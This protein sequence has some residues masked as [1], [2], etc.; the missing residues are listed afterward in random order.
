[1]MKRLLL[2]FAF[3]CFGYIVSAQTKDEALAIQLVTQNSEALKLTPE[4][5]SNF[6][7]SSTYFN[8][9]SG[10]QL[11]YLLQ[12]FKGLPVRN[13]MMVL[14]F[15][16]GKPVSNTGGFI[17]DIAKYT[18]ASSAPSVNA[19]AAIGAA[20]REAKLSSP[21]G[22]QVMGSPVNGKFNYG[23]L[24]G[25]TEN[26]T[27]ELMWTVI[28][29][30]NTKSVKL[31]WE[32]QVVPAK[33]DDYW[34]I[35][36]DAATGAVID[37]SNLT[38]YEQLPVH[39]KFQ[40]TPLPAA[41]TTEAKTTGTTSLLKNKLTS[42]TIVGTANYLVI[43]FPAES[44]NAPGGT[45]AIRTNPW[46]SAP[47]NATTL[48]WHN[49]GTTDYTITRGNNVWATEDV[50]ATN[51]NTGNPATSS[52][53]P[54]PLNFNF[55]PDYTIYPTGSG[56]QPFAI[57]NLFYWN[58]VIHDVAYQYGFNEVAGNFQSNNLG[59]GGL[60]ND[61]VIAL[62]QSGAAGPIG[63]NANFATPPDGGRGR[64]RMYLW[65]AVPSTS[66]VVNTPG[67][68]AGSY[69]AVES[70]YSTA[71][72]LAD[73]GPITAQ[74]AWFDDANGTAHEACGTAA[75]TLTGKIALINRGTCNFTAKAAAA[76]AAGAV[77]IIMIN[78]VAGAPIIMGGGPDNTLTVPA[79][80]V[81]QADGA[82]FAA[83]IS[84]NLNVTLSGTAGV[85]LDGDIDNGIITHEFGHGISNRF[86]GGPNNASCLQNAEQG[87]EG[88]SDYFGLMMT[89]NWAT[90][91]V[92]DGPLARPIGTYVI[93]Q[94][95]NGSGIRNYPYST[96]M[97][98]NPLTYA[99]MGTGA[100]GTEVHNIG[101]IWCAAIWDMTWNIIIQENS[102]NPNLYNATAAGGNSI[103]LKLVFEGMKLQP[104]SPGFIDARNA[105]ITADANLYGGSHYCAIW[106]AFARRGMGFSALQGSSN[107][108]TDQTA[109][110]DLPPGANITGQPA[111]ATVCENASAS[112]TVIAGGSGL[113]YQ[114][115]VSTN[116]GTTWTNITGANAA[117][118]TIASVTAAMNNNK[119]RVIVT[120]GCG[121]AGNVTSNAGTL[122][123]TTSVPAITSQPA[124]TSVCV[125][126]NATFSVTATGQNLSYSWQV[127]TNGGTTFT[128]L[129]PAVTTATLTLNAVTL[130]MN[131]NQYR[132]VVSG[133]CSGSAS[134]TSNA[135]TLSISSG[136]V[137]IT[138]QPASTTVCSGTNTTFSVTATGPSLTYNW[139]VSTDNGVTFT[140]L[141]PAVTT[142]TLTLTA[143]TPAMTGYQYRVVVTG[144]GTCSSGG[145][146]SN[147]ATL[148][149]NTTT[150]ITAQPTDQTVCT[151]NNATFCVTAIG[152]NLTYQWQVSATG[153]TGT[154]TNI[155][156]ATANCLTI[157]AAAT[158]QNGFAYKC[159]VTGICGTALTTNCASL[160]VSSAA[161]ITSQ[162]ANATVCPA[163]SASFSITATGVGTTYQW[164]VSTNGGTTW[165]NI[166]GATSGTF[167]LTNVTT[168]MNGN[169]YRAVAFSCGPVGTNS[170]AAT[171][172]VNSPV[173]YTT[174]PANIAV[175]AGADVSFSVTA[176]GTGTLTYQWQVST[177]GGSTW[178]NITGATA[179]TLNLAGV[180]AAMNNNQ[181]RVL[182]SAACSSNFASSAATLSI[183]TPV[184]ITTQPVN[185]LACA[186]STAT[187]TVVATGLSVT[188]Q[189]Q[190]SINGGTFTNISNAGP[191]SGAN[192][193]TLALSN[194]TTGMSGYIYRVI[195]SGVPCGAV[196][197]DAVTLTVPFTPSVVIVA[198]QYQNYN[199]GVRTG[200]FATAS[201]A[202]PY[203]YQWFRNNAPVSGTTIASLPL[204]VDDYGEYYVIATNSNG[205][206]ATSNKVTVSD[207]A[208]AMMFIYPNPNNGQFQVRYYNR[209]GVSVS[210]T[211]VVY[212]P[213]GARVYSKVYT[214]GAIYSRMD[215]DLKKPGAGVYVVDLL[216]EK[217]KRLA[218][219]KVNV[220]TQ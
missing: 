53:A 204:S 178:I 111:N 220:I 167:T 14:A 58:N 122:T 16:N 136:T 33:T 218:T 120:G 85:V 109:A 194:V 210:R 36:I 52:T 30:N 126:T 180:T 211:L 106:N 6:K 172:T 80:M 142:P 137:S 205:C 99:N 89:T 144:T 150:S 107:S 138:N 179:A 203:T 20:F 123:V 37:K 200:L 162:P 54:D 128:T 2:L 151:G 19:T 88:W 44:R 31:A 41:K 202:V 160:T 3:I 110:F 117:T 72:K 183:N 62:A 21:T 48:G 90:A 67:S 207:S 35:R 174:Q 199:P 161:V 166:T 95:T 168:A 133:G 38:V 12:L 15:K 134:V 56:F 187:F 190:V 87:G 184:S 216:D 130:S 115:Q 103:A 116:G 212:D 49:N 213:K 63:N 163:T 61:D 79:V 132:V 177:N 140:N 47:G 59:R 91:S 74:V 40:Q 23:T 121:S 81:S 96:N 34:L 206:S 156:G 43:P 50:A 4:Q 9:V 94:P 66:L 100:I 51:T 112:F 147:A 188:Y 129:S 32:I 153:C 73:L 1:M 124:N 175:C 170:N 195:A 86:T 181:Y 182:S 76:Q 171:L 42:P 131:N 75:T 118:Y 70:S 196:T 97:T 113:T 146:N 98:T 71:N 102:V 217:G 13:Q 64:M 164:Q 197:S 11:V 176:T 214:S 22:M 173:S 158:A 193:N 83:Q 18:T 78:N 114:W 93:G 57:T 55:P 68:I 26:V 215:V 155:A 10:T 108:A 17:T 125:G 191:T 186:G 29:K 198:A 145:I 192:S 101:E 219:G 185:T 165:T 25:V 143:I 27:A 7:V 157:A 135:A 65:D 24:K 149:V 39:N 82:L 69:T 152:T 139:Q 84:N 154:F 141:S 148:T 92:N 28:E 159:I 201:P 209:G 208:S 189:W 46:Q 104:C 127:S 5:L 119:Y 60:G 45:E 8:E 105:I 77:G 169:L